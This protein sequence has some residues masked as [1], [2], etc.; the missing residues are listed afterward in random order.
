MELHLQL[1]Y[2]TCQQRL[3]DDA[4]P[5]H[6]SAHTISSASVCCALIMHE[7]I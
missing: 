4:D 3:P 2:S 1:V 7:F 5:S 6:I